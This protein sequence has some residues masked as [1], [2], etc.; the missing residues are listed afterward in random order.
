MRAVLERAFDPTA[1]FTPDEVALVEPIAGAVATVTVA[2][3]RTVRQSIGSLAAAL[4]SQDA[5]EAGNRLKLNV[6]MSMLEGCDER[7]LAYACRRCLDELDWMPTIH[8]LK[9]RIRAWVSPEAVAI[10]RAKAVLR[11]RRVVDVE[12]T[13]PP[14]IGDVERVNGF[15]RRAGVAT[16]FAVDGSTYQEQD[17]PSAEEAA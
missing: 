5:G 3:E 10:S 17:E 13:L 9:E 2:D 14:T 12:E 4:P 7:A 16:R 8:Q 15:L 1:A 6:Y 11:G